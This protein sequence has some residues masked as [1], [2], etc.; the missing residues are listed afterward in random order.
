MMTY[1]VTGVATGQKAKNSKGV[2]KQREMMLTVNPQFP[3]DQRRGGS[4][5]PLSL[6]HMRQLM[7]TV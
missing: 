6:R 3:S 4:G 2:V 1:G 7:V 5:A